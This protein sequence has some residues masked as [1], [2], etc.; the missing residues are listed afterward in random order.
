MS[1]FHFFKELDTNDGGQ[2]KMVMSQIMWKLSRYGAM[3]KVA[4]F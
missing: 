2:T 1:M 4:L 3:N